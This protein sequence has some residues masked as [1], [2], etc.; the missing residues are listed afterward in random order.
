[1]PRPFTLIAAD[2]N[3]YWLY[4]IS[5]PWGP[6]PR[7]AAR[8]CRPVRGARNSRPLSESTARVKIQAR[9]RSYIA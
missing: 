6:L 7:R 8:P 2:Q 4:L 9:H 3:I 1:M 5:M